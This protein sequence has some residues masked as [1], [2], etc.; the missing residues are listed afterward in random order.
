MIKALPVSTE[1]LI[2]PIR[3]NIFR[4]QTWLSAQFPPGRTLRE[5]APV[6]P[7]TCTSRNHKGTQLR[8]GIP[9]FLSQG[10]QKG[11]IFFWKSFFFTRYKF[12]GDSDDYNGKTKIKLLLNWD[13]LSRS[14]AQLSC[15]LQNDPQKMVSGAT[16][17]LKVITP[18]CVAMAKT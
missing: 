10:K 2:T 12:T 14:Y 11:F 9:S 1:Y 4:H 16:Q 13:I 18:S 5:Q 15:V 3:C 7:F 6:K 8:P 17:P